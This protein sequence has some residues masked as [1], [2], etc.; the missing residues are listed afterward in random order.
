MEN[1]ERC[2]SCGMPLSS[3]FYGTNVDGSESHDYCRFC[4]EKGAFTEPTLTLQEMID[5]SMMHMMKELN[6]S[7]EKAR[8]V[9]H[10]F[11]PPLKRWNKNQK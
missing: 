4:F 8:Y 1:K 2:Q 10:Q 11:L 7:E 6:F 9:A 3:E 5:I